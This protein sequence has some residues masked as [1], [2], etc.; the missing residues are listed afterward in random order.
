MTGFPRFRVWNATSKNDCDTV[1]PLLYWLS[2]PLSL[3]PG[4]VSPFLRRF[5]RGIHFEI[6]SEACLPRLPSSRTLLNFRFW[7]AHGA[8]RFQHRVFDEALRAIHRFLHLHLPR[9]IA[10]PA[11]RVFETSPTKEIPTCRST[12]PLSCG[13]HS[14]RH[15]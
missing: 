11:G 6:D 2:V 4:L 7:P 8:T 12:R 5:L 13:L 3:P 1:F 10:L 9:I 15:S 14:P